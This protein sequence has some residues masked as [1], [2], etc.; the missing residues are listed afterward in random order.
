MFWGD[1]LKIGR[2]TGC[3]STAVIVATG[4][5]DDFATVKGCGICWTAARGSTT[6]GFWTSAMGWDRSSICSSSLSSVTGI[7]V[8]AG[9]MAGAKPKDYRMVRSVWLF[10]STMSLDRS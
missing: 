10:S 5:T 1:G 3:F 7:L 6:C 2:G 4:G 9:L 8:L